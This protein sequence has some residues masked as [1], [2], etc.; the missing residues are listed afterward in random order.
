MLTKKEGGALEVVLPGR[1]G[2]WLNLG[3]EG[4][5]WGA[6]GRGKTILIKY[7][8]NFIQD[9]CQRFSLHIKSTFHHSHK[10]GKIVWKHGPYDAFRSI[11]LHFHGWSLSKGLKTTRMAS[12]KDD[13]LY[14]NDLDA[15]L[16]IIDA[17]TFENDEDTESEIVTCI[18]NLPSRENCLFKCKFCLKV[19]LSKAGLSRHIAGTRKQNINSTLPLIVSAIVILVVSGQDWNLLIW[20]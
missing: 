15:I 16:A 2:K 13:F 6:R 11:M 8:T 10:N 12:G 18:K 9:N 14:E 4:F 7:K 17:D 20:V 3:K 19:C 1:G 5:V